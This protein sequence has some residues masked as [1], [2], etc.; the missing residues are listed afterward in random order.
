MKSSDANT[1][2]EEKFSEADITS[3][4]REWEDNRAFVKGK[5]WTVR[6]DGK[7]MDLKPGLQMRFGTIPSHTEMVTDNRIFPIYRTEKA[8]LEKNKPVPEVKASSQDEE[9]IN[10]AKACSQ[11]LEHYEYDLGLPTQRKH[12]YDWLITTGTGVLGVFWNPN[13]DGWIPDVGS[14]QMLIGRGIG[15]VEVMSIPTP[16]MRPDPAAL[17]PEE[18]KW[19]GREWA[20]SVNEVYERWGIE[21]KPENT[22]SLLEGFNTYEPQNDIKGFV[23]IKEL[24]MLPYRG[25]PQGRYIVKA[26]NQIVYDDVNPTC[27]A[28]NPNGFIPYVFFRHVTIPGDFWGMSIIG[29]IIPLQKIHNRTLSRMIENNRRLGY[30]PLMIEEG[31]MD[32]R[33]ITGRPGEVLEYKPGFKPPVV[34]TFPQPPPSETFILEQTQVAMSDIS[35]QHEVSKGQTPPGVRAAAAIQMLQEQDDSQIA[36]TASNIAYGMVEVWKRI[37]HYC[38]ANYLETRAIKVIGRNN[39]VQVRDFIASD[40]RSYDVRVKPGT[41]MAKSPALVRQ[42]VMEL[43]GIGFYSDK[44]DP[45]MRT[46]LAKQLDIIEPEQ[47]YDL[48]YIAMNAAQEENRQMDNLIPVEVKYYEDHKIHKREHK[49]IMDRAEFK[50]KPPEVQKVFL[51]HYQDHCIYEPDPYFE[52]FKWHMQVQQISRE[53]IEREKQGLPPL[54]IPPRPGMPQPQEQPPKIQ[55]GSKPP[56][57]AEKIPPSM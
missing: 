37:L 46:I 49:N 45:V 38:A 6:Y 29:Q 14:N 39:Q 1:L 16:Q 17:T 47:A 2:I 57:E 41:E 13:K 48:A 53:N 36:P 15:D 34:P 22:V 32:K 3:R 5:Q 30:P 50:N 43:A 7:I 33:Q 31:T 4:I 25:Y 54:E 51:Q 35:A 8:K 55:S 23:K 11:L 56:I 9:D 52:V 40:I 28:K 19:C 44:F 18:M 26:G 24:W 21:V 10:A 12:M 20:M 27:T 42:Q